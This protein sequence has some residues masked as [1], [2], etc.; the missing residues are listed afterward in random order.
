M[1]RAIVRQPQA[2]LMDEPLSN[3]DAKLRVQMR[4]EIRRLQRDLG[5]TTIYVTHDQV[6][7]MTLGDLVAVMRHGVVQ[8]VDSPKGLYY[9]PV[10]VF[11][12]GFIGSPAMNLVTARLNE[13]GGALFADFGRCRLRV[14]DNGRSQRP[15]LTRY[16][17]REV[18]LGM[19]P[20]HMGDA[21][22]LQEV[23]QDTTISTVAELREDVGAE[24]YVHFTVD[25]PPANT[26]DTR[27]LARTID[28][29][30]ADQAEQDFVSATTKLVARMSPDT[31]AREGEPM[32]IAVDTRH[33]YFFDLETGGA[34]DQHAASM[35]L[36]TASD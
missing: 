2:F 25:A 34:I 9:R 23:R 13:N 30:A 33:L 20:E 7:A 3:L 8:Q 27:E 1:G 21:R 5:V 11:V 18:I 32:D 17:G 10:N 26:E 35:S 31:P 19:R 14:D 12:A 36:Q 6:E 28:A 16:L 22:L 15:A 29:A 24:T 4:A